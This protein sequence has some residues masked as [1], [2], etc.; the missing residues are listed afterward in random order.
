M[1]NPFD[2]PGQIALIAAVIAI[3]AYL[4]NVPMKELREFVAKEAEAGASDDRVVHFLITKRGA[5]GK[6]MLHSV[7]QIGLMA[8]IVLLCF[9]LLLSVFGSQQAIP[10]G[11]RGLIFYLDRIVAISALVISVGYLGIHLFIDIP[12]FC[13]ACTKRRRVDEQITAKQPSKQAS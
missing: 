11:D 4:R 12:E 2:G 3:I 9:R 8:F 5:Y 6:L 7:C 10:A 1:I 13:R